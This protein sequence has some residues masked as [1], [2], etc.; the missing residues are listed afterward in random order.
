[1][2]RVSLGILVVEQDD[3]EVAVQLFE[4]PT[5]FLES[6]NSLVDIPDVSR[7]TFLDV[8]W[9]DSEVCVSGHLPGDL[10][11]KK[12]RAWRLG[13]GPISNPEYQQNHSI[14]RAWLNRIG[15]WW[16]NWTGW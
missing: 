12:A 13:Y 11:K 14:I 15:D 1:M 9:K 4:N 10:K 2:E 7:A 6:F 3:G 5:K 8:E 16:G